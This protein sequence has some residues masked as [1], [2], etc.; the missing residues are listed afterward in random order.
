MSN[1]PTDVA[2]VCTPS[3]SAGYQRPFT[4]SFV[5]TDKQKDGLVWS[6]RN[7]VGEPLPADCFPAE[8][9]ATAKARNDSAYKLPHLFSEASFWV[10][11]QTVFDVLQSYDLGQGNLYPVRV[12]K[13]DRLT[14]VGGAW[15]CLNFGNRKQSLLVEQSV[16]MYDTYIYGGTKAWQPKAAI[17]DGDIVLDRTALDG[18]D[19]WID[20]LLA[21]SFFLSGSLGQALRKAKVDKSF[22]LH[23]CQI[24]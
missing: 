18:P 11:S 5:G 16:R 13:A 1:P 2:W 22:H 20:P 19:I 17:K 7:G 4:N 8:I 9:Y 6:E 24:R 10:V 3:I 23:Q 14:P 12:L 15:Y 21:S